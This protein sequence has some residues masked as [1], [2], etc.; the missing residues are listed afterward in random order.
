MLHDF[1][2]RSFQDLFVAGIY[3]TSSTLEWAMVELLRSLEKLEKVIKELQQV[4][5]KGEQQIEESH[6]SKLPFLE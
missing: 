2:N 3:T 6:I 1:I 4:L 5:G